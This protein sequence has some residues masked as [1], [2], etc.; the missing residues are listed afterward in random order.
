M[1]RQLRQRS[2]G[3][4]AVHR[5]ANKENLRFVSVAFGVRCGRWPQAGHKRPWRA[6]VFLALLTS[7]LLTKI[8]IIFNQLLQE[9]KIFPMMPRSAW[10]ALWSL[11]C[12]QKCSKSWAK[13]SE[14]N[15]LPPHMAT[16]W[17]NMPVS[18]TLSWKFFKLQA[19]PAEGQS[20]QQKQK[21]RR[22]RKS[23]WKSQGIWISL[24]ILDLSEDLY[25]FLLQN[26][27]F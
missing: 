14:Q 19:S 20:L 5:F 1:S 22:K 16:P 12:A 11:R 9:E 23:D 26:V 18:M 24:A 7:S 8:G 25:Q 21:K 6:L 3:K 2:R 13:N 17:S 4:E 10:S 15:F 27:I